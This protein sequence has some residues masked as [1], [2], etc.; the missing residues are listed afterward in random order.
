MEEFWDEFAYFDLQY[1]SDTKIISNWLRTT[2]TT[3][4]A[5][6]EAEARREERQF[7]LN[8]LDGVDIA[9]SECTTKAIRQCL[10]ARYVQ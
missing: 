3:Y 7:I 6:H 8:I 9:D 10:E 4:G 1:N 5:E 2:L